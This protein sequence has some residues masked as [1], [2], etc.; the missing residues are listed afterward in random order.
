M[1]LSV[2]IG[3]GFALLWILFSL[4]MF[5][6][7][8]SQESFETGIMLNVFVLLCAIGSG[9]YFTRRKN[10]FE[11]TGFISDFK[12]CMQ[13]GIMYALTISVFV[14]FYHE[15]IDPSI[16]E[17]LHERTMTA[18]H[19]MVPDEATYKEF[20]VNDPTW[21]RKSF[22]DY[23]ENQEDQSR[24]IGGSKSVAIFH[25]A[26]LTFFTFFYSFFATLILRKIVLR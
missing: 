8:K 25:M 14:Y 13:S 24:S 7:G 19:K 2:R 1:K 16:R 26:G 9:L 22:D 10:N 3:I 11:E 21:K 15:K 20:Q 12:V 5:G 6:L 4:I 18:V 23:I 17:A